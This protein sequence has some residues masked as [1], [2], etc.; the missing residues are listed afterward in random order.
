MDWAGCAGL[1]NHLAAW[2]VD[3]QNTC[4][5]A[6]NVS[7]AWSTVVGVVQVSVLKAMTDEKIVGVKA[8]TDN[9]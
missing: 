7:N 1:V 5:V 9:K 3:A 4:D 6:V 8:N 2:A